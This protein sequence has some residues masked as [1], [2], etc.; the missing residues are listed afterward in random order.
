MLEFDHF[1]NAVGRPSVY[2]ENGIYKMIYSYRNAVN[3]RTDR[4]QSYRIGYAESLDGKS[5]VR[6]DDLT[7]IAKS[8]NPDDFDYEMI[9]YCHTYQHNGK[10]YLLYN[11]N[12]FGA[13][14][15]G[16]AVWED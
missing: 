15:F 11:G 7:G 10:K 12:G 2:K 6:K 16:Y 1:L 14:G 13:A 8:E 5:W 3:Y 4:N 9:N